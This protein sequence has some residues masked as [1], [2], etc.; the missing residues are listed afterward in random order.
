MQQK[1]S[2]KGG[3][4]VRAIDYLYGNKLKFEQFLRERIALSLDTQ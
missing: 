4:L 1:N 3:M 2:S